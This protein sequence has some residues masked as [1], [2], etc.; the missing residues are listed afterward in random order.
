M[1]MYDEAHGL[2]RAMTQSTEMQRL[3]R[4]KAAL[5]GEGATAKMV[6][7]Y[8]TLQVEMQYSQMLGKAPEETVLN[9]WRELQVLVQNNAAAKEYLDAFGRWQVIYADIQ[10]II[11]DAT[12][13]GM[14]D[15]E[16]QETDGK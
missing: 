1:N 9:E 11:G 5:A 14:P 3:V 4:A 13:D 6:A 16:A 12:K 2:A 7:R 8:L 15:I 10:K